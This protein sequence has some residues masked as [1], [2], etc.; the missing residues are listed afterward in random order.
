MWEGLQTPR[1]TGLPETPPKQHRAEFDQRGETIKLICWEIS[2][3]QKDGDLLS[4]SEKPSPKQGQGTCRQHCSQ[5]IQQEFNKSKLLLLWTQLAPSCVLANTPDSQPEGCHLSELILFAMPQALDKEEGMET[6]LKEHPGRERA[7]ELQVLGSLKSVIS[8]HPAVPRVSC[9]SL[10]ISGVF[11]FFLPPVLP[12]E[13]PPAQCWVEVETS[14][15]N[16]KISKGWDADSLKGK[17][18]PMGRFLLT[19]E[20]VFGTH[21]VS[22][23][24]SLSAAEEGLGLSPR[25]PLLG[26]AAHN[27]FSSWI[28]R[29]HPLLSPGTLCMRSLYRGF[30]GSFVYMPWAQRH[31]ETGQGIDIVLLDL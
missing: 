3:E 12:R 8:R 13:K 9:L 21:R 7:E 22:F 15:S 14:R 4:N 19:R 11:Y 29:Q 20:K 28:A 26:K 25:V 27:C 31:L 23:L 18:K 5:E 17:T 1:Q 30:Q 16:T 6:D 24:S 2:A 10:K